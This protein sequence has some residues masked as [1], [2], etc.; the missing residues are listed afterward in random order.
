[1]TNVEG[2]I[3]TRGWRGIQYWKHP[4]LETRGRKLRKPDKLVQGGSFQLFGY[5]FTTRRRKEETLSCRCGELHLPKAPP[6]TLQTPGTHDL[7]EERSA[8]CHGSQNMSNSSFPLTELLNLSRRFNRRR[9]VGLQSNF[10]PG[11]AGLNVKDATENV[12]RRT[13]TIGRSNARTST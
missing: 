2:G 6:S 7:R 9:L 4:F 5:Y 8:L 11:S 10:S 1:M 3:R 12:S 13:L